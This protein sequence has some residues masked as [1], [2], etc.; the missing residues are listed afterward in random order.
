MNRQM[1]QIAFI[2]AASKKAMQLSEP[3]KYF[4]AKYEN[5]IEF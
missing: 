2:V 1:F 5:R 3:I 4:P